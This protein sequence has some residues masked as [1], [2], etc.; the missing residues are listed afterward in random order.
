MS[1]VLVTAE[2]GL[3]CGVWNVGDKSLVD[4]APVHLRERAGHVDTARVG[5][6]VE[7]GGV[8]P[9]RHQV[10]VDCLLLRQLPPLL[11]QLLGLPRVE[12]AGRGSAADA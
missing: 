4:F 6:L 8:G 5:V 2:Y 12:D 9:H 11:P 1:G 3:R 7:R 10:R